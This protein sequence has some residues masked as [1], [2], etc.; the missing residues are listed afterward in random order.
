M[1]AAHYS[2]I[3]LTVNLLGLEILNPCLP[4][5]DPAFANTVQDRWLLPDPTAYQVF[6]TPPVSGAKEAALKYGFK[7]EFYSN[8]HHYFAVF[9][10]A[11]F[12]GAGIAGVYN[13]KREFDQVQQGQ[14]DYANSAADVLVAEVAIKHVKKIQEQ[15]GL[16][17][18]ML[19][20]YLKEDACGDS[21]EAIYAEWTWPNPTVER[22][23]GPPP[24]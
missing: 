24:N 1:L 20:S 3:K 21:L 11:W 10:S 22:V 2:G 17:I 19:P 8:T 18:G 16:N 12:Y 23:L 7:R 6:Q 13:A 4:E 14:S 15:L 5:L 9:Y